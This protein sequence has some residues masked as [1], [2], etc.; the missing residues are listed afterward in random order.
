M[1]L[2]PK[3]SESLDG[4]RVLLS[5]GDVQAIAVEVQNT[6]FRLWARVWIKSDDNLLGDPTVCLICLAMLKADGSFLSPARAPPYIAK[7]EYCMRLVFLIAIHTATPDKTQLTKYCDLYARW[8]TE[9]SEST[10]NSIRSLT[11]LLS[12]IAYSQKGMPRVV[13]TD[14]T[15]Y[16]SMRY[17]GNPVN[18][19]DFQKVFGRM[20]QEAIVLWEN[21]V[22]LGHPL[23]IKYST[24]IDDVSNKDV[25]YSFLADSRNTIFS[26]RDRLANTILQDPVLSKRFLT[27]HVDEDGEPIWNTVAL[28]KWLFSYAKFEGILLASLEMKGGSPGRATE[29]ACIEYCNTRTRPQRGLYVYGDYVAVVCQYHKS[30]SI[31]GEDK[32]LPHALD[33]VT[34]DLVVQD[35]AIARPFAELA[36]HIC[37]PNN[38]DI[39]LR[40]QTHLFVNNHDLFTTT[41]LSTIMKSFTLPFFG[42][43]MGVNDWR[44]I[45]AA[46]RR[47]IC[48]GLEEI[49]EEDERQE[50]IA[51]LQSSH[52]RR[53]ED[54][55]YGISPELL[56][57][58]AE[59]VIPWFL[60]V[61]TNWQVANLMVPGGHLLPYYEAHMANFPALAASKRIK[62]QYAKPENSAE[63][64]IERVLDHFDTKLDQKL[65]GFADSLEPRLIQLLDSL[66]ERL[67]QRMEEGKCSENII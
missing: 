16:R 26:D 19:Q 39:Q 25:N 34:S 23:H 38:K 21:E 14:R 22:L 57:G 52:T 10:F 53:T 59:D 3:I 1:P 13:W 45:T 63:D 15:L 24:I 11:H 60:D 51:A 42:F 2:P 66:M 4:L 55:I 7:L 9:K 41:Q 18:F 35:L 30:G 58:P 40:Y 20:E 36:V 5:G 27:G 8:F 6:L 33:A 47:K 65:G 48:L 28:Q 64:I 46:F 17:L 12:S 43:G 54:R 56:N 49:A 32:V 37:Y 67:M 44:H 29:L 50:D 61:S 31:T 62:A